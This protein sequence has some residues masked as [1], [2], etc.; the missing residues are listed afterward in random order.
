MAKKSLSGEDFRAPI[1]LT[2]SAGTSGQVLTSQGSSSTPTWTSNTLILRQTISATG[3]QSVDLTGA[4]DLV[5]AVVVGAGGGG[6]NGNNVNY[7]VGGGGGSG[8][9]GV[10][11]G[12]R[13]GTG[14][15]LLYW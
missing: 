5:Y 1:L 9:N 2:G 14:C 15:V 12:G 13:G 4:P 10:A 11:Q 8:N 6:G 7:Q 3:T